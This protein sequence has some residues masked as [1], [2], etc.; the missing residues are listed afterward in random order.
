MVK[1]PKW[2]KDMPKSDLHCHMGGSMRISTILELASN[3]GIKLPVEDEAGLKKFVVYKDLPDKSLNS[4]LDTF[5]ICE[6]VLVKPE[7]FQ[8]VAY[9]VCEDAHN[10]GVNLF[11]LRFGPTNYVHDNLKLHEIMEATLD[12]IKKAKRNFDMNIG[13]IV[14]GIRTKIEESKQ[15]AEIAVNY[16]DCGV[17]GF[18]F[19]GKEAGHRPKDLEKAI[20]PVLHNFLPVTIHAGEDD[21]VGSIAEALIYLNARRIGHGVTLR[22]STKA[23]DYMNKTRVGLEICLTSNLDTGAVSSFQTHPVKAYYKK[24]LRVSINTDNRTISDTNVTN[25]YVVLMNELGFIQEDVFRVAKHGIKSAFIDSLTAR[26]LLVKF[27]QYV[28]GLKKE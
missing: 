26:D 4:Y 3:Y 10:E 21:T 16:Q 8:R 13:L 17:V 22:E 7:A 12:G 11:E 15:A 9:E 1:V 5:E 19:A 18:D 28:D 23:F 25:E 20:T 14:C 24:G 2:L 6:S 27:D